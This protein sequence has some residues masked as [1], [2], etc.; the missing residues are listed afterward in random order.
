[1][2]VPYPKL[3]PFLCT[4]AVVGMENVTPQL[5]CWVT[6]TCQG[7]HTTNQHPASWAPCNDLPWM[8]LSLILRAVINGT[9]KRI[10]LLIPLS[11]AR[12]IM[13]LLI[14]ANPWKA[15]RW[16]QCLCITID[17]FIS[18]LMIS[19]LMWCFLGPVSNSGIFQG[20][21]VPPK[22]GTGG[23]VAKIWVLLWIQLTASRIKGSLTEN[24]LIFPCVF[25]WNSSLYLI[26]LMELLIWSLIFQIAKQS[27]A[28]EIRVN[29]ISCDLLP[30]AAWE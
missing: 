23:K 30:S 3:S 17:H 7:H 4:T 9:N 8:L 1:M 25:T 6:L 16:S 5:S 10:C 13:D 14:M 22:E 19:T 24:P 28:S 11:Q 15:I 27:P 2:A 21:T 18:H 29:S 26:S 20:F 12:K